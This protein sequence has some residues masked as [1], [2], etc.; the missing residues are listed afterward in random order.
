MQCLGRKK[1][2]PT[3]HVCANQP[4]PI[5]RA[6]LTNHIFIGHTSRQSTQKFFFFFFSFFSSELQQQQQSLKS[7]AGKRDKAVLNMST[8]Q[9][10]LVLYFALCAI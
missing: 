10:L 5:K 8:F 1:E 6:E 2:K 7:V 4:R 9:R 3:N